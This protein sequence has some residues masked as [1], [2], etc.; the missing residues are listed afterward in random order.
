[1]ISEARLYSSSGKSRHL[2][3]FS[4]YQPKPPSLTRDSKV[5]VSFLIRFRE[6]DNF[7]PTEWKYLEVLWTLDGPFTRDR[8]E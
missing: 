7:S 6:V 4:M 1:M 2:C 8:S 3:I 5:C